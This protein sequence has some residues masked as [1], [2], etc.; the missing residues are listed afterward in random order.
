MVTILFAVSVMCIATVSAADFKCRSGMEVGPIPSH[1]LSK[2]SLGEKAC[3]QSKL[4]LTATNGKKV[5]T[6]NWQCIKESQCTRSTTDT[7]TGTATPALLKGVCC[8][9]SGCNDNKMT[10]CTSS[11]G[12]VFA[13]VLVVGCGLIA[14]YLISA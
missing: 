3:F 13:N 6:Y 8:Y 12:T 11:A 10:K 2:C 9:T 4:C 7:T 14:A 5:E 1:T